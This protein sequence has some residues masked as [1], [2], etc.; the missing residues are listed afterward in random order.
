[1]PDKAD[2]RIEARIIIPERYNNGKK[3]KEKLFKE[4]LEELG[5]R[6]DGST[7]I[8]GAKGVWL[9]KGKMVYDANRIVFVGLVDNRE[10]RQWLQNYVKGILKP[11]FK[12]KKIYMAIMDVEFYLI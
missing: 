12:Q 7:T 5:K 8:R 10:N 2:P 3:I 6:F 4:T 9:D 11:R 1:M